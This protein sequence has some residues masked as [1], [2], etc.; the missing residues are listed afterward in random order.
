RYASPL[1]VLDFLKISSLVALPED[2]L[3][4]LG[5]HA[6]R[7]ARAEG[8]SGHARSIERRLEGR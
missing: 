3:D 5:P 7:L 6:A 4:D 8:L 2:A 1:S